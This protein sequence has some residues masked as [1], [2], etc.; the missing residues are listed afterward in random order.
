LIFWLIRG[1]NSPD[2][3][4]TQLPVQAPSSAMIDFVLKVR[5][6]AQNFWSQ[7]WSQR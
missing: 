1:H 7:A 5:Q 3:E 2:N 6:T 4:C